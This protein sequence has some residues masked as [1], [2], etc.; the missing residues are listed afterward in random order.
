MASM[1]SM[2]SRGDPPEAIRNFCERNGVAKREN[3]ID[4]ALL[5]HAV[6]EELNKSAPRVM[7]VLRPLRVVIEN[8]PEGETEYVD[9]VNNPEDPAAGTRQVP[10]SRELYIERDDFRE[11]PPNKFFRLAPGLEGGLRCAYFI[12]RPGVPRDH[13]RV[14][15][16]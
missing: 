3:L 5:E 8:Y 7:G 2:R 4:V 14:P 11:D 6:R 16:I 15:V 13:A 9:V 10:F 12:Q 1:E